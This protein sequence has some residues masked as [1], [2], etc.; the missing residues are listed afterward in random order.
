MKDK[1]VAICT[2]EKLTDGNIHD[3]RN[4]LRSVLARYVLER[5]GRRPVIVAVI[6]EI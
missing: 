2:P 3:L 6:C 4:Q 5:T 1:V